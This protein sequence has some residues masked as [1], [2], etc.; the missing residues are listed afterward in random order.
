MV[1]EKAPPK[2]ANGMANASPADKRKVNKRTGSNSKSFRGLNISNPPCFVS[3]KF[4]NKNS[5]I[6]IL[7]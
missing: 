7:F 2:S 1:K 5:F 4:Q 6:R 3:K